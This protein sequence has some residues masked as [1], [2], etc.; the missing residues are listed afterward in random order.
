M[1]GSSTSSQTGNTS[2]GTPNTTTTTT[3]S[4][5]NKV[6]TRLYDI[7]HLEND[8]SNY[9]YWKIQLQAI[10]EMQDLWEIVDGS[11]PQPAATDSDRADWDKQDRAARA[12]IVLT[13]KQEPLSVIAHTSTT[14]KTHWEKLSVRYEGK[15]EQ[16]MLHLIDNIFRSTLSESEPLQPQIN[17]ILLAAS[18][19]TTLSLPLNDKLVAFAIISSLPSSMST[20]KKILSNTKPS[21]M[22]TE[23][24]MSQI[25]LDEQQRV[26]ESGTNASAFF[27]KIAKKGKGQKDKSGDKAKK[28]CTHCKFRGHDVKECRKLK[29]EQEEAKETKGATKESSPKPALAATAKVAV[30]NSGDEIVHLFSAAAAEPSPR[31]NVAFALRVHPTEVNQHWIIDSGASRTMSCNREWFYSFTTLAC[32]IQVT[33]GDNSSI[34]ATGVG[35]IPVR[36]RANGTWSNAMLQDV[37]YVP[38]LNGNLL[39]VAHLA[40]RG[41]DIRFINRGCQLYTQTGE[42]TCSGQLQDKLYVM[43]MRTVVPETARIARVDTFPAEGDEPPAVAETAL[44][45]RTSS[46]KADAQTWHRRLG[47]LSADTV[48]RM[49]KHGMVKGM[50]ISGKAALTSPCEPCLKGKQTRAEISKTTETRADT[51]LGRVFSDVCG[52]LATRSHRGFEYF[53]TFTDDKSRKVFVAGLHQKSEVAR[54]SKAFIARAELETGQ[55]L[56]ILRSD[57]G[58]KYTGGELA[59]YL[60]GKG[61]QHEIT[62]PDTPQ[63]NG[64]AEQMNRT[65]LDKVRAMLLDADLPESYWYDALEYATLLHNVVPT[66]PLGD[67]TPEEAWSGNKPDVSRLRVFGARA[68]VHI[69]DTHRSKLAAKLL[70]CTFLGHAQN[71]RAYRLVHRPSHRFLESRDVIFDEGGPAARTSFEHIVIEPDDAETADAEAGGVKA[72]SGEVANAGTGGAKA[73]DTN[74]GDAGKAGGASESDKEIEEMLTITPKP[75]TPTIASTRPKRTVRAPIRDDDPRYSVSSYSTRKRPAE[76][77]KVAHADISGDPRTYTQAMARADA[78]EW[79]A[80]CEAERRAFEHMGVYE[81]VPRPQGRKVVGSKWVFRIKRGPDGA[82]QKYKARIVAQGFSQI[83][84]IDYD[85]TF[86][87]VAK[88]ASLRVILALAAERDLEVHQMDVKLAYLNGELKEEIFMEAPPGFEIPAGMVLRLVKA[89]YG[90]KQGGRVWYEEIRDKLSSM[91]Y[92]RTEADH[93][94]FTRTRNSALSIIAL[95]VDDITMA[96]K[97]IETINQDKAALRESYE[98]TDLGNIS[99]ILGMHVTCDRDAGW[100]AISQEK[101]AEEILERFGKS[102]IRPIS[103]PTLAN[104]HLTKL[105]SPEIDVKSYQS[106]IGALMYPMLGTRP[107]L[108]YTVA[109]LGRHSASP[110]AEHQHALDR[111]FRYLRATSNRR[112]VFQRGTP[113]GITLHGFVDADW[114][115][116]VNDRKSMSGFVFMLGGA[117]VSWSSKKQTSVALSSTEAEYIAA[118]HATKEVI[119]LRRLLTDLGLDLNSPTTL[120]IDNQSA[121]AIARNPEFHDRTKHIEIRHHFL[122]QK[123]EGEEIHLSYIPTEDQTADVLTKG[124]VREKHER[125]SI[126]MGLCR[127]G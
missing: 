77:A 118:A 47:H 28:Q 45:A 54:H 2:S 35:R 126:A 18:K 104:E 69:P 108:A 111:A 6:N 85:E 25:V 94:V 101:Y 32:P 33:L 34:S 64:V 43:D 58:G 1:T 9:A 89:V 40:E 79:E 70:V 109:A 20:L 21:D 4:S 57:G 122:R 107:D 113:D 14:A 119:W 83:E 93:A 63:H 29:K 91:G 97:D 31:D 5:A 11:K 26:R 100:I 62:T 88:F 76:K 110:G 68:F 80:A 50:E 106:A 72:D 36:M 42:L 52:K 96:S 115:S 66:R 86:A 99:W 114:A 23:N 7:P 121:I 3:S 81:V 116:D 65:L 82:I 87:P 71:R 38:D 49:V 112:L 46:S 12:Q 60:E 16:R 103:T 56:K 95:Y 17:T 37:L 15:G 59:K 84:G 41:A 27:A 24:I 61:I 39:S 10:L 120:H 8:G 48:M 117:A 92:Q 19:V 127:L 51:T 78:A 125:F 75:P 13:L 44:V 123:V 30:A 74:A 55:R 98:M 53:V 124:L 90:T 102:D 22:T 67:I 73:A 105:T